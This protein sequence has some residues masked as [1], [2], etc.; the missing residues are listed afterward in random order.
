MLYFSWFLGV[1]MSMDVF[2]F[3][4][5]EAHVVDHIGAGMYLYASQDNSQ[6]YLE[7]HEA[8]GAADEGE[9]HDGDDLLACQ[10]GPRDHQLHLVACPD[11]LL[12]VRQGEEPR[13]GKGVFKDTS[14]E[15]E[16]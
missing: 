10:V 12:P 3:L 8:E 13:G 11:F 7:A 16:T 9:H 2:E 14:M 5:M 6:I 15:E 4:V 1:E